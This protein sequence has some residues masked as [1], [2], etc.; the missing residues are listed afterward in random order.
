MCSFVVSVGCVGPGVET[1]LKICASPRSSKC[2]NLCCIV[3]VYAGWL[4]TEEAAAGVEKA[5]SDSLIYFDNQEWITKGSEAVSTRARSKSRAATPIATRPKSVARQ[6]PPLQR[7]TPNDLQKI[8]KNMRDMSSDLR[9]MAN[10][11][12]YWADEAD[13]ASSSTAASSS[14][15]R[16]R[17]RDSRS[18]SRSR[19][20]SSRRRRQLT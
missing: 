13:R 9:L 18:R 7:M 3:I 2:C 5:L 6:P 4:C 19:S 10:C 1:S 11:M 17:R 14:N 12:D 8:R 16:R 20:D 15:R